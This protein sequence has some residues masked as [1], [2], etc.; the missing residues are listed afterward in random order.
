MG[1]TNLIKA[2]TYVE[3]EQIFV[4]LGSFVETIREIVPARAVPFSVG[5]FTSRALLVL[6][7]PLHFLYGK[8]NRFL[9]KGPPWS[10]ARLPSYWMERV[11]LHQP[12]DDDAHEKEVEWVLETMSDGLRTTEVRVGSEWSCDV[13]C[14]DYRLSGYG[15]LPAL[16]CF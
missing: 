2:S 15:D 3:W 14:S 6:T 10:T 16:W 7:N 1:Y 13:P 5:I 9:N 11:L 8:I 12:E 4:L